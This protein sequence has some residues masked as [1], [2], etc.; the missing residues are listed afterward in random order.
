VVGVD[1]KNNVGAE[2][3]NGTHWIAKENDP[4]SIHGRYTEKII[5]K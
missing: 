3:L 4:G 2:W 5:K 1:S